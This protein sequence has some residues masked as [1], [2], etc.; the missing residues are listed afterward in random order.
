MHY[1][2]VSKEL[3]LENLGDYHDMYVECDTLLLADVFENFK[4]KFIDIYGLDPVHFF[5]AP[6]LTWQL[7]LKKTRVELELLTDIDMLWMVENGIRGGM[8]RAMQR[9]TKAN[10]K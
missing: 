8:C 5:C 7:C 6:G 4:D 2:K 3:G 1:Q 10:N 9:Y